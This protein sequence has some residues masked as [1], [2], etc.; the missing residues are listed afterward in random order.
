MATVTLGPEQH[1]QSV[2]ASVGDTVV[3]R[4]P[5]NPTT[6]YQWQVGSLD[7]P[8]VEQVED[9]YD[10]EGNPTVGGGGIRELIFRVKAPASTALELEYRRPWE[11]AGTGSDRWRVELAVT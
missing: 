6:G 3:V 9:T 8:V 1:G 4:L 11:D 10:A 2:S 7:E 5:E